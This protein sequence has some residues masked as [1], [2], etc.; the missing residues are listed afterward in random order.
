MGLKIDFQKAYDRME[1][2]FL[3]QVLNNFG[4]CQQFIKIVYQCISTVRYTILIKGGVGPTMTP[5]RGLRQGDPLSPYLFILASE[6]LAKL[7]NKAAGNGA[8]NGV[9][10][11]HTSL[12][13]TKLMYADDVILIC[14]AKQVEVSTMA[15]CLSKYCAWSGQNIN[16]EKSGLFASHGVH[17]QFLTQI[18]NQRT[19]RSPP[20]PIQKQ[21]ERFC[22]SNGKH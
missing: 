21:K 4:F 13:I 10:L 20:I 7:T 1:W 5:A 8:I 2:S 18:R 11:G 15:E 17:S 12:E 9:K 16:L 3:A 6:V 14:K 19:S 22:P